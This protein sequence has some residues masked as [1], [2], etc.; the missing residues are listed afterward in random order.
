[1][2][3]SGLT[4]VSIALALAA[5]LEIAALEAA[6]LIAVLEAG[7]LTADLEAE[8]S[9]AGLEAADFAIADSVDSR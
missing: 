6:D 8:I 3:E 4:L 7:I 5:G 1:M 9:I 2:A